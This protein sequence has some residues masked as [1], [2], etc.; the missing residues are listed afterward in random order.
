MKSEL[1][2]WLLSENRINK[3]KTRP[4]ERIKQKKDAEMALFEGFV[5]VMIGKMIIE[6]AKEYA[7]NKYHWV[8][9]MLSTNCWL[10]L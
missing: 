1:F 8:S 2:S 9:P 3:D 4:N 7:N 5:L 6:K 10:Y